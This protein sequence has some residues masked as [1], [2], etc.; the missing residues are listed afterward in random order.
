MPRKYTKKSDYWKKFD[1][2]AQ[3]SFQE[4]ETEPVSAGEPFHISEASYS[5]SDSLSG[6]PT[7]RQTSRINRSAIKAPIARYSQIRKGLLPYEIASDGINVRETIELCQKAYANVPIFRNTIDMMSEFANTTHYLE[8]G[9]AK[10]REFFEKLFNRIRLYDLKNQ[11]F[12]EYYR[13]GNIFI[14]RVDGKFN[15]ENYRKFAQNYVET[16]NENKFPVKYIILN[17]FDIVAKRSTIF[18]SEGGAYAKILSEFDMERLKN[19]K[20]DYDKQVFESLPAQVQ[21]DILAGA[22]FKDGLKINLD[23]EKLSYS[24]YKKQDY[25]PFAIPFGYPV[26]E[27]INAKMEMKKMDQ[28]IMRTVENVILMI[29]MGAEPDK[30]GINH[31]NLRAMQKLFQN[32]SVGRV[33]VSDH[34]TKADFVIPDLNRVVGPQKYE[35]INKDI[36]EGLQNIILND[37][38]YNGAQIKARVF[39]DRLKEARDSFINDFLQPEIKRISKDLGFRS[40]PTV[41]FQ[42]MD[43]RDE[44]Q[45]MRVATR[46]MELGIVTAE[47]GMEIIQTGRFPDAESLD[48]AQDKFV[49]QRKKGYFNPIVG[50][51]P[52]IEDDAPVEPADEQKVPGE[53]GRPIERDVFSRANIQDVIVDVE[54]LHKLATAKMKEKINKKRLTKV[55][56]EMI[57]KLCEAVVCGSDKE[58]WDE[59]IISCVK[60]YTNIESLGALEGV[61]EISDSHKLEI[62]PSAILYHSNERN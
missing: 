39:L 29:T 50:G 62:Y 7:E 5:R 24:F 17:P 44:V 60:D 26:L 23:N 20:N 14:Y 10:S 57:D 30:G 36:K 56:K 21:K 22:Y 51:I 46:L 40:Y 8:G 13:S 34:T 35:V 28:A 48:G 52:M 18:S 9:T 54:K 61:L 32:E 59:K 12:R 11:Y 19:P 6:L 43:L 37:D 15:I 33:L 4:E 49:E 47:Q 16:P 53:P 41:R 3:A 42:E 25:E 2:R 55:Q 1:Q 31:N 45:L 27:D 58:H 38:K